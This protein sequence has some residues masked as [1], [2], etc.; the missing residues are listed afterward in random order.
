M[1]ICKKIERNRTNG[2]R[3]NNFYIFGLG[4]PADMVGSSKHFINL[5]TVGMFG[6]LPG[7]ETESV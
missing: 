3:K 2:N 5:L 7:R 1:N 6:K 4:I